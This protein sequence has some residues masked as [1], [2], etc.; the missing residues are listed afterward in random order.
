MRNNRFRIRLMTAGTLG[1]VL[2]LAGLASTSSAS[3]HASAK[4]QRGGVATFAVSAFTTLDPAQPGF[5]SGVQIQMGFPVFDSL[6]S[7]TKTGLAPELALSYEYTDHYRTLALQ[8]RPKVKFSD[9]TAFNSAA[10][11]FN[12]ARYQTITDGVTQDFTGITSIDTPSAT[13]VVVHFNA[14]NSNFI[15]ALGSTQAGFIGSPTAIQSEGAAQFGISPVGAGPFKVTSDLPGVSVTYAAWPGYWDARHRYLSGL[16]CIVAAA[17]DAVEYAELQA[18][19]LS[20]F[21]DT[22][23]GLPSVILGAEQNPA[24][25]VVKGP[26]QTINSLTINTYQPPFN[27]LM[28]REA[29]DYC[30]ARPS[31]V[32]YVQEGI[33]IPSDIWAGS[34][35]LYYPGPTPPTGFYSYNPTTGASIVS[36]LGGISFTILVNNKVSEDNQVEEFQ[37]MW[38]ACG[39]KVQVSIVSTSVL[40]QMET[41]GRFQ[42][43]Y[44]TGGGFYDPYF[45]MSSNSL[46]SSSA[47]VY[48]FNDPTVTQLIQSTGA[49]TNATQ[50]TRIWSKVYDR[51]ALLAVN[52]PVSVSS[53][54]YISTTQL[55]GLTYI[56]LAAI[57]D[58]AWLAGA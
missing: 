34:G 31:I 23:Q 27:N 24:V 1:L 21:Y 35:E 51:E 8:L 18:G 17:G 6:F 54:Y 42:M 30:L 45:S 55:H 46:P 53:N 26:I 57:Y 11:K 28:A 5:S 33:G 52:I 56:A 14:P 7:P 19:S 15:Q 43:T 37:S 29:I 32:K 47:D 39:M 58:H 41:T 50:L 22:S 13:K 2:S 25:R 49:T 20:F 48:G 44:G 9:G 10:V 3:Q 38:Q 40:N 12:F 16:K 36:S 4:P